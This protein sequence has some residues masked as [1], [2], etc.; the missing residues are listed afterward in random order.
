[1][2]SDR[3]PARVGIKS[4][5]GMAD[6]NLIKKSESRSV[7]DLVGTIMHTI[8]RHSPYGRRPRGV[9]IDKFNTTFHDCGASRHLLPLKLSAVPK[10]NLERIQYHLYHNSVCINAIDIGNRN[11]I[12]SH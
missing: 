7:L 6:P 1:L 2:I 8:A 3:Q 5:V 10:E 12:E 9:K 4:L 11:G